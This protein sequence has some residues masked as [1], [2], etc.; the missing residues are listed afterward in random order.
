MSSESNNHRMHSNLSCLWYVFDDFAEPTNDTTEVLWIMV[1]P[2]KRT[3]KRIVARK[4][5]GEA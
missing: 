3:K 2:A 5:T 4:E 1:I